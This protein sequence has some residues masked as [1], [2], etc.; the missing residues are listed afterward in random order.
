MSRHEKSMPVGV[1][2]HFSQ[3]KLS[4]KSGPNLTEKCCLSLSNFA[5]NMFGG[6]LLKYLE[7]KYIR[8]T[9][10]F[11]TNSFI[12]SDLRLPDMR[13]SID[14]RYPILLLPPVNLHN[15]YGNHTRFN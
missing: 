4:M 3:H 15:P 6:F 12:C 7:H 14:L 9:K 10:K 1:R 8:F 13:D 5:R 2:K 11:Q